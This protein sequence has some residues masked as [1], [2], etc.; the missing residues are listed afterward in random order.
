VNP[1]SPI[2]IALVGCGNIG[3]IHADGLAKLADD[4][5]LRAVVAADPS[6]AGREAANRN[7]RFDRLEAEP[8]L[9]IAD[10][11]VEAVLITAPTNAHEDLV[12]AVAAQGKALFCE[13]P[14]ARDLD[15]ARRI[16]DAVDQ[17]G[18]PAQVGF[19]TRFHPMYQHLR[20][21]ITDQTYGR[22]M[23]YTLRDDQFFPSGDIVP[24]HSTWRHDVEQAGGGAL[25]EHS[26][27]AVDV[28]LWMFGPVVRVTAKTRRLFGYGI[29]DT[30]ALLIEHQDGTVGTLLTIFNGVIGREERRFEVF[31]EQASLEL[32]SDFIVGA[33]EDSLLI[34]E[35]EQE[36]VSPDLPAL[37]EAGFV[38]ADLDR[39]DFIFYQ[40]VSD[41]AWL[42][43][44]RDGSQP[45]PDV[46]DALAA[47]AVVDAA[48][49][50]AASDSPEAPVPLP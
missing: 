7:C 25:L 20:G 49:R 33:P 2:G 42:Q 36:P 46:T 31:F 50:S 39:R 21:L 29:E 10:P 14:L 41:R 8:L 32:T 27:H 38:T 26:I 19:H 43:A 12:Q 16:W 4:G 44:V 28:L 22:T 45:S 5:L 34:Q 35:P 40:Y 30:A 48:Y 1:S 9:A 23:G 37:R 24:G 13:K 17:A 18:I 47:H 15:G 11:E 6:A 3:Q